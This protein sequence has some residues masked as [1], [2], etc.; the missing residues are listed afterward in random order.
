MTPPA[1]A[2]IAAPVQPLPPEIAAMPAPAAAPTAA[3][4]TVPCCCGVMLV[5]PITAATT[6]IVAMAPSRFM[7][8]APSIRFLKS[9]HD[10]LEPDRFDHRA[11]QPVGVLGI[12]LVQRFA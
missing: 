2:P 1:T 11:L 10:H 3:P 7:S 5:H 4:V 8:R 6:A 9:R 12:P